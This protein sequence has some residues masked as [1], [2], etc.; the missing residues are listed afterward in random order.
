[1]DIF[2][3]LRFFPDRL[4]NAMNFWRTAMPLMEFRAAKYD[5]DANKDEVSYDLDCAFVGS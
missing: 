1:V 2:S 5:L 4:L 3:K